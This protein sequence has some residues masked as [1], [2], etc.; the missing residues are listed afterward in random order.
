M[1]TGSKLSRFCAHHH[2]LSDLNPR[3]TRDAAAARGK[4]FHAALQDWYD[5][6]AIP[7]LDDREVSGW[8]Q[9][10]VD[11]GW[12]WPDG[13]ELEVLWGLGHWG[14][15]VPVKETAPHVYASID[16]EDL[17]TAG[18]ADCCWVTDGLLVSIDWKTGRTQAPPASTNLQVNAAGLALAQK[19]KCDRYQP[20][21][22]YAREGRWD[23]GDEVNTEHARHVSAGHAGAAFAEI[24]AAAELDD[25]PHPGEHCN[26]CWERKNCEAA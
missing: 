22:Y 19:W 2:V 7:A 23:M 13:C 4:V 16:G 6:G 15:F 26:S 21:I 8:L 10:M 12:G 20:G 5:F 9:T 11:N 24:R 25:K 1:W 3:P 17:V 14:Q 18:R